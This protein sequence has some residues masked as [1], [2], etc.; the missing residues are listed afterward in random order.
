M[1]YSNCTPKLSTYM[2]RLGPNDY[3]IM[4]VLWLSS[5]WW[6]F[7]INWGPSLSVWLRRPEFMLVNYQFAWT[8]KYFVSNGYLHSSSLTGVKKV[9]KIAVCPW[10]SDTTVFLKSALLYHTDLKLV[11]LDRIPSEVFYYS[12]NCAHPSL[13]NNSTLSHKHQRNDINIILSN[14]RNDQFYM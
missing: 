10:I 2:I 14:Q 12:F 6:A 5:T 7:S 8:K 3:L 4:I 1:D 11:A 13:E 9:C